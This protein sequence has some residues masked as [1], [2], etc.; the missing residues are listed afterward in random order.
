MKCKEMLS[1]AIEEVRIADCGAEGRCQLAVGS[2][3]RGAV[4]LVDR[5]GKRSTRHKTRECAKKSRRRVV[6]Y[7]F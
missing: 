2:D 4:I 6:G 7:Q 3:K 1:V 5:D